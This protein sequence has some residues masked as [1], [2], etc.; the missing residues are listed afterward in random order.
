MNTLKTLLVLFL[1]AGGALAQ[2]APNPSEPAGFVT[3]EK[4]WRKVIRNPAL[5]RDPFEA[6]DN[7]EEFKR[8][9]RELAI[10]NSIRVREGDGRGRARDLPRPKLATEAPLESPYVT[11]I[12]RLKFKNTG[13][14]AIV[15][16]VWEY[17][18]LDPQSF[19]E[20]GRHSFTHK[21][22]IRSGKGSE[23]VGYSASPPA[24]VVMAGK[25]GSAMKYMEKIVIRRIEYADGST[26]SLPVN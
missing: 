12:Y 2:S 20:V 1:M 17:N 11:Y 9:Q 24:R 4:S 6:N 7:H 18:F 21:V 26:W 5:D 22:K 19:E 14:K 3:L 15:G 10:Q 13:A 8:E 23:L 25:A 16:L